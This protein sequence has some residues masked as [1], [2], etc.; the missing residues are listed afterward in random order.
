MKITGMTDGRCRILILDTGGKAPEARLL[1]LFF[2]RSITILGEY[3][4]AGPTAA[5]EYL[6]FDET[7][8]PM[9][10]GPTHKGFLE[11]PADYC[12]MELP[13]LETLLALNESEMEGQGLYCTL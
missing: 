10:L 9:P 7:G 2:C 4:L 12:T 5:G 3:F 8:V 6:A 11:N 1:R 13:P